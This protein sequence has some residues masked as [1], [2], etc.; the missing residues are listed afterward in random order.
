MEGF[1][2]GARMVPAK[3]VGGDFFDF[4]PLGPDALGIA[5]GDVSGKGV[6]AALFMA[7]AR[8]LLRA[9]AHNNL[10]PK[11][12]L[13][14]VNNHLMDLNEGEMFVTILYGLINRMNQSFEYARAG[15]E[16]PVLCDEHGRLRPMPR[17]KGQVLGVIDFPSLDQ[18]KIKLA[19]ACTLLLYSDGVTDAAN[20]ENERFGI[21]RVQEGLSALGQETAQSV[22]DHLFQRVSEHQAGVPQFDDI[23]MVVIRAL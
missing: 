19:P 21:K 12:V 4:I 2:F 1:E 7:M 15:H 18:Q 3:S 13:Q 20:L 23:T 8:S 5:I 14:R 16:I 22:C 17:V 10:S 11:E 9:E 6:P